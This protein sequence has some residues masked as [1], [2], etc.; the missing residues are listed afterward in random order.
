MFPRFSLLSGST[1]A[2]ALLALPTVAL[3]QTSDDLWAYHTRGV[4]ILP[5]LE[6]P[7][8]PGHHGSLPCFTPYYAPIN[9]ISVRWRPVVYVPYYRGYCAKHKVSPCD[10]VPYGDGGLFAAGELNPAMAGYGGYSGAPRD[11]AR[12]LHLGGNGPYFPSV[13]GAVDLIDVLQGGH[14]PAGSCAP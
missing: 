9:P 11:E 6:S 13:P 1:V 10:G 3:A 14:G 12:L 8:G 4:A 7:D 5:P 2:A